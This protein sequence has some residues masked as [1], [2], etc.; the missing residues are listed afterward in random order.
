[1]LFFYKYQTMDNVQKF[2]NTNCNIPSSEPFGIDLT[3]ENLRKITPRLEQ[4]MKMS[5]I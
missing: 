2:N 4:N 5:K 1:M 3:T